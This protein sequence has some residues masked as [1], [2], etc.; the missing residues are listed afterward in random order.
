[1]PWPSCIGIIYDREINSR[2]DRALE[3]LG[4]DLAGKVDRGEVFY[5]VI[6][7]S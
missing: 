6:P 2:G 4:F 1:M 5:G 7:R 3:R